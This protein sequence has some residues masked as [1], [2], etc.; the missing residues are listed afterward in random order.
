MFMRRS[1]F[2]PA[3][4]LALIV[5][6]TATPSSA[7]PNPSTITLD[8]TAVV[9]PGTCPGTNSIAVNDG[10]TVEYCYLV[11]N[12]SMDTLTVNNLTDSELGT[13][14]H[15]SLPLNLAPGAT[16]MF[17][18]SKVLTHSVTNTAGVTATIAADDMAL[19]QFTAFD[20]L[21]NFVC[22]DHAVSPNEECDD[23]N[24]TDGD[25][26][27]ADC[28]WEPQ[29]S[30]C[31]ESTDVCYLES[32]ACTGRGM[33]SGD[34][35]GDGTCNDSDPDD[36]GDGVAD[37]VENGAPDG[38]GNDD[39]ISDSLQSD[40]TSL[41]SA[42]GNGYLTLVTTN[43]DPASYPCAPNGVNV[44]NQ[45]V[46][47]YTEEQLGVDQYLYPYGLLGFQVPC[48]MVSVKIIYH[49]S[50][51]FPITDFLY[52]KYG[53]T[54]PGVPPNVFYT[55]PG[56]TLSKNMATFTLQDNVLGDATGD[57]GLI[58]DPSGLALNRASVPVVSPWGLVGAFLLLATV[59]LIGLRRRQ[60][61]AN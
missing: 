59:G 31:G 11:K 32:G 12:V 56:V 47:A 16:Q 21:M 39:N 38:D 34:L 54:T 14:N 55:L 20:S 26:C 17:T 44:Q 19:E 52:R 2:A 48:E 43:P 36:D 58:V 25:C 50:P 22:G 40:V 41:P 33:C 30:P 1:N 23:G 6:A 46:K 57:D 28:K 15:P 51:G 37:T 3:A 29:G 18:G 61:Q 35:D 5:C 45:L 4:V 24:N 13:I 42:T 9:D 27:S 60:R 49:D 7:T 8:K 53:P 10:T